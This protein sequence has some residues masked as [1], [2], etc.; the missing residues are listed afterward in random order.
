[1]YFLFSKN[2]LLKLFIYSFLYLQPKDYLFDFR[3][4]TILIFIYIYI[5]IY[6]IYTLFSHYFINFTYNFF[7][8]I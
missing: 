5:Y 4:I 3:I 1:F 7:F 8:I 6:I 2:L